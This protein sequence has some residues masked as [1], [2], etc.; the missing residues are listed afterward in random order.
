MTDGAVGQDLALQNSNACML[1]NGFVGDIRTVA[2]QNQT[3]YM[4]ADKWVVK[5]ALQNKADAITKLITA[6]GK[7]TS[8]AFL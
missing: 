4:P 7:K 3:V 8:V 5:N 6:A 2:F 1:E